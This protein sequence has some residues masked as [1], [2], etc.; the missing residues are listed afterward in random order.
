MGTK[1]F[2]HIQGRDKAENTAL[3]LRFALDRQSHVTK[4][5]SL[6]DTIMLTFGPF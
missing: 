6:W 5:F 2:A 1:V 4:S 3:T